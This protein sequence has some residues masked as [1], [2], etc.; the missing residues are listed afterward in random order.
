M[1]NLQS[2]D[3]PRPL[4]VTLNRRDAIDDRHE[5]AELEYDH[6]VFDAAAIVAQRARHR[7]QG[8]RG[9]WFAG[10]YWGYGFHE[11]GVQSARE[12]VAAIEAG[13]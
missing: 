7:I 2:I 10:A 5:L 3:C 9:V 13:R 1:N 6:P 11:D 12:V 4:L 8:T